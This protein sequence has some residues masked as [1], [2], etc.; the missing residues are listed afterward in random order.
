MENTCNETVGKTC[1]IA[2]IAVDLG[3]YMERFQ[4]MI[5]YEQYYAHDCIVRFARAAMNDLEKIRAVDERVYDYL[6][7]CYSETIARCL[8][9]IRED[10]MDKRG[11]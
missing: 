4:V 9:V 6:T 3:T 5:S 7:F 1:N 8:T 2:K 10:D 11:S